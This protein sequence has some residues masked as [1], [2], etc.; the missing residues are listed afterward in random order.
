MTKKQSSIKK[1]CSTSIQSRNNPTIKASCI[2]FYNQKIILINN[3]KNEL[4]LPKGKIKKHESFK[5]CARRE[6]RE[7]A[8]LEGTLYECVVLDGVVWYVIDVSLNGDSEEMWRKK[9]EVNV[10]ESRKMIK[11]K[12][13]RVLEEGIKNFCKVK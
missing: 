10:E 5:E 12:Y 1:T 3:R 8:R 2:P 4:V 6:T 13:L 11:K 9:V 7:E